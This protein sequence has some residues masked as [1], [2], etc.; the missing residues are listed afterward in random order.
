[1]SPLNHDPDA[2]AWALKKSGLTQREFARQ[3]DRSESLV[4]EILGG[5]RNA[6]PAVMQKMAEVLNCPVVVLE[7]KRHENGDAA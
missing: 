3:I 2:L 4:S 7:A 5:T 6:S 1:M